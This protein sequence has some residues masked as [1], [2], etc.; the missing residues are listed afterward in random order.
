MIPV[1]KKEVTV[2]RKRFPKSPTIRLMENDSKRHHYLVTPDKCVV[3]YLA[4][5]WH[6]TPQEILNKY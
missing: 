3:D 5:E 1:G 6:M 2:I 4:I